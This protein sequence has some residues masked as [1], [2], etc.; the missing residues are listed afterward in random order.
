[1]RWANILSMFHFQITPVARKKN[2]VVGTLSQRPQV[3]TVSIIYHDEL[4]AMKKQYAEDEQFAKIYD[5]RVNGQQ[6]EHYVLKDG[7]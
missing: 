1:M 6:Q 5:Q 3:S 7:S 4:K 2:V